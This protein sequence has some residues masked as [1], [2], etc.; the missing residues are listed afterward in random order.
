MSE[1][2]SKGRRFRRA[3]PAVTEDVVARTSVAL[4]DMT[5]YEAESDFAS[6]VVEHRKFHFAVFKMANMPHL[7]R[8]LDRLWDASDLYRAHYMHTPEAQQRAGAEHRAILEAARSR[9]IDVL[10]NLMQGHRESTVASIRRSVV[11]EPA[12]ELGNRLPM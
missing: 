10:L 6:W 5:A 7:M 12:T 1:R 4:E 2:F 8:I 3:V 9:N 11:G